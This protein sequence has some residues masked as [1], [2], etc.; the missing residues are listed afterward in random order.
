MAMEASAAVKC[1]TSISQT[2]FRLP[3]PSA[4]CPPIPRALVIIQVGPDAALD[5]RSASFFFFSFSQVKCV[6]PALPS[7]SP[8]ILIFYQLQ[9]LSSSTDVRL[10]PASTSPSSPEGKYFSLR[11][12]HN[13]PEEQGT[14]PLL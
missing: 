7:W 3:Q 2:D 9:P 6:F 11:A 1:N 13:L 12:T 10:T 8:I 14:C 5:L 4:A